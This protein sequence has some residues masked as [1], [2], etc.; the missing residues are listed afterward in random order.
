LDKDCSEWKCFHF[1]L[2]EQIEW[3]WVGAVMLLK[4]G[5]R[6]VIWTDVFQSFAMLGGMLAITLK[7]CSTDEMIL[8]IIAYPGLH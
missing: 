7:V 1:C 3:T 4:G 2:T 8:K 5:M 6:A